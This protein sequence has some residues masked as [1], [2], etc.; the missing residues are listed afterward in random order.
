MVPPKSISTSVIASGMGLLRITWFPGSMGLGFSKLLDASIAILG[1]EGC[2]RLIIDLRGNIGGGLGFARLASYLCRNQMPIGYSV[3]RRRQR[4]GYNPGELE[5][6][7]YPNSWLGFAITLARFAVR[8]KSIFLMTQGIGP[9]TFHRKVALLVNEWTNSAAEMVTSFASENKLATIIGTKT[10]GNVL[11]ANNYRVGGGYSLRLP[12]FG[13]YTASGTTVEGQGVNPDIT[14][15]VHPEEL[16]KGIDRQ[17]EMA[18]K[19]LTTAPE[20]RAQA[21]SFEP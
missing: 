6:V 3:S 13:W 7:V 15:E 18:V 8:D 1:Q 2:D 16:S 12:V 19:V 10:A 5:R 4:T 11:G 21:A 20:G 17:L 14:V 9:Q